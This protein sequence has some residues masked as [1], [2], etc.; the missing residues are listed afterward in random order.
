MYLYIELK[1]VDDASDRWRLSPVAICINTLY[2]HCSSCPCVVSVNKRKIT[3]WFLAVW[4]RAILHTVQRN[5]IHQSLMFLIYWVRTNVEIALV[6]KI[7]Y[8]IINRGWFFC[9]YFWIIMHQQHKRHAIEDEKK[10]VFRKT[11]KYTH[12]VCVCTVLTVWRGVAR[13]SM[14]ETGS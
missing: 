5:P 14:A 1:I 10:N 12:N 9:V 7:K 6:L 4:L 2:C 3:F 8:I 13:E 11:H